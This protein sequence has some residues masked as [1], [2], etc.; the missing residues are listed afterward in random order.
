MGYKKQ[1]LRTTLGKVPL[2]RALSK[3]G[4]ASR[5]QTR[6]W[7]L[8][9]RV[10]VNK[11]VQ[12]NPQFMVAPEKVSLTLDGQA[13][14][15]LSFR[16]ILFYKPRGVVT[17][18]ADEKGRPTVFSLLK[19]GDKSLHAVGR[20]DMATSGLLLFTNDTHLSD[21]LTDPKNEIP[22]VYVATVT[23]RMTENGAACLRTGIKDRDGILIADEV[24]LRKASNRESHLTVTLS[25]GKN[26]EIRRMFKAIGHE[27][28]R[29]KR[30]AFGPLTLGDLDPG[31]YREVSKTE[32]KKFF[33][34]APL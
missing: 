11:V 29:L 16:A 1:K 14:G 12:R 7:I 32:I 13:M 17:T 33:P 19:E 25:E 6:G 21:W 22:R 34:Q 18:R 26:R 27:V 10:S 28:T 2:E 20:L 3:L 4:I 30:V 15:K 24:I 23:G 5:S 8:A 9:G 31:Q